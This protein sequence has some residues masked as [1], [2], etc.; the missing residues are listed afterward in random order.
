MADG[1]V[2]YEVRADDSKLNS[3]ID[4]AEDKIKK[5]STSIKLAEE[6]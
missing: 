5:S 1:K 2:V 4:Q 6:S 3:D